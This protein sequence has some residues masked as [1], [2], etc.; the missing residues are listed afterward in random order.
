MIVIKWR[1]DDNNDS[2]HGTSIGELAE[3]SSVPSVS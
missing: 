1:I 3:V 2:V